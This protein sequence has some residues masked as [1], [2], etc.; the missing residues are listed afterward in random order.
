M[1]LYFDRVSSIGW[2]IFI[3]LLIPGKP[4]NAGTEMTF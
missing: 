1:T 4:V 2:L 3:K